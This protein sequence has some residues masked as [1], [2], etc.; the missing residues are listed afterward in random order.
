MQFNRAQAR[1]ATLPS[2]GHAQ[3]EALRA[4]IAHEYESFLAA[5][6]DWTRV[7]EQWLEEKK[8]AVLEQWQQ[9]DLQSKFREIERR[10]SLQLRRMRMLQEQLA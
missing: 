1:L 6:A 7:K 5:L 2:G 4:R 10:L 8:R 3:L 9:V